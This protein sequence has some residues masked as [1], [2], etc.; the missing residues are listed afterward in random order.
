M[1]FRSDP[2]EPG[3]YFLADRAEAKLLDQLA[4]EDF[5]GASSEIRDEIRDYFRDPNASYDEKRKTKDWKKVQ[6]EL[7]ELKNAEPAPGAAADPQS[8]PA[9]HP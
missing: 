9:A 4:K 3:K 2:V 5:N 7:D 1:L 6:A 8:Q